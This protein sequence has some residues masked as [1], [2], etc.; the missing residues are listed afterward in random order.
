MEQYDK[1]NIPDKEATAIILEYGRTFLKILSEFDK[2]SQYI[3]L[4]VREIDSNLTALTQTPQ[5]MFLE[6][7]DIPQKN[8]EET[9]VNSLTIIG[10]IKAI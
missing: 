9:T 5:F 2:L 8:I 4:D 1:G 6:R 3:T 10:K 7:K